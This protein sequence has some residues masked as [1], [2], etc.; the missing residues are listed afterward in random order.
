MPRKRKQA[1]QQGSGVSRATTTTWGVEFVNIYLTAEDKMKLRDCDLEEI[2]AWGTVERLVENG[3]KASV[4][5]DY[6]NSCA[7]FSVTGKA[8]CVPE[9]NEGRCLVCRAAD[10][11]GAVAVYLYKLQV[12]CP[13]GVFPCS[14]QR[15]PIDFE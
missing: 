5:Y 10:L 6:H 1:E 12:Y 9:E 11:T 7:V 13:E 14:D 8:G 15:S 3:Y 4:S 2:D